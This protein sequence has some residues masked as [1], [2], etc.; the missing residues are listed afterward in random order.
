MNYRC[1]SYPRSTARLHHF[2]RT[3][4]ATLERH[5]ATKRKLARSKTLDNSGAKSA[6]ETEKKIAQVSRT[7]KRATKVTQKQIREQNAVELERI[8]D[9]LDETFESLTQARKELAKQ[10]TKIV[11]RTL[12]KVTPSKKSTTN[13]DFGANT[14]PRKLKR[15]YDEKVQDVLAAHDE[16]LSSADA[17]Q[18]VKSKTK[19]AT[20][21]TKKNYTINELRAGQKKAIT[22]WLTDDANSDAL[23][24]KL[25]APGEYWGAE[26]QNHYT[27]DDLKVH[28]GTAKTYKLFA[29]FR[30]LAKTLAGYIRFGKWQNNAQRNEF[31]SGIRIVKFGDRITS[32]ADRAKHA[33]SVTRQWGTLKAEET[34]KRTARKER[35]EQRVKKA[36]QRAKT[37]ERELAK[38]RKTKRNKKG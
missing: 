13:F 11:K 7:L 38:E 32:D 30:N 28:K 9:L 26:I 17:E 33:E 36:E 21:P 4:R 23:D 12:K 3:L 14:K 37:A 27:G 24:A 20:Y 34:S 5:L 6:R 25:L 10:T 8:E 35:L 31:I 19:R 29:H 15:T 1:N 16:T 18:I 2:P 22:A